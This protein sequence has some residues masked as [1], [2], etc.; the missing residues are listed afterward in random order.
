VSAFTEDAKDYSPMMHPLL[1]QADSGALTSGNHSG[2]SFQPFRSNAAKV[3]QIG[4]NP[5]REILMEA[6]RNGLAA[7]VESDPESKKGVEGFL[8]EIKDDITKL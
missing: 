5:D 6:V 1:C 8:K 3:P 2:N 4:N 7:N